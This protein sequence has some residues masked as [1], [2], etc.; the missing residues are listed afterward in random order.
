MYG[1]HLQPGI[2]EED[3]RLPLT[4]KNFTHTLLMRDVNK[5]EARISGRDMTAMIDLDVLTTEAIHG[6]QAALPD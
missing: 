2:F 6:K 3:D 4:N 1:R 5:D